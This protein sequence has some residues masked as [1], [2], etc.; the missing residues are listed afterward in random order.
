MWRDK[1]AEFSLQLS[2]QLSVQL[3]LSL[4]IS[5]HHARPTGGLRPATPP[6]PL[7]SWRPCIPPTT[8][9]PGPACIEPLVLILQDEISPPTLPGDG[10]VSS[11]GR[12]QSQADDRRMHQLRRFLLADGDA[13]PLP[14]DATLPSPSPWKRKQGSVAPPT[15][16]GPVVPDSPQSGWRHVS[17][18]QKRSI[19]KSRPRSPML[20]TA[21]RPLTPFRLHL[22]R[23]LALLPA[24]TAGPTEQSPTACHES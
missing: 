17:A 6:Q 19:F 2:A 11:T 18:G 14:I 16:F 3:Q 15:L 10:Q 4:P 20:G 13:M 8:P 12:S 9:E 22:A 21:I 23:P 7:L 24:T 1:F 5:D